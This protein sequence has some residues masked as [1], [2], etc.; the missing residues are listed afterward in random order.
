MFSL[1][2][3]RVRFWDETDSRPIRIE[4]HPISFINLRRSSS[5]AILIDAWH[6]QFNLCDLSALNNSMA[7]K[8]NWSCQ[9]SINIAKEDDLLRLMK[10]S[11]CGSILIGL[12]SVSSQN[13][14]RM[15]KRLNMR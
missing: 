13:L 10:D 7:Y 9:A 11:G 5:F 8:L 6:D 3:M 12:E 15:N 2:F 4:P 1:L 14:T